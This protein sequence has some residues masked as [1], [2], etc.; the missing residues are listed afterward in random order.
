[1]RKGDSMKKLN[2]FLLGMT[3]VVTNA[4]VSVAQAQDLTLRDSP[5][6]MQGLRPLGMGN[7]FIATDG[8]DINSLF[9]NPAGIAD[10][11]KKIEMD[12]LSLSA[13]VSSGAIGFVGDVLDLVDDLDGA[14]DS[15]AEV[16]QLNQFAA[17]HTGEYQEAGVHLQIANFR[18]KYIA[19]SLF[20]NNR[21]VL[22]LTNPQSSTV[23][24]EVLS[25]AGL[26]VGGAYSFLDDLVE[27]GGALKFM[28]RHLIDS[29]ISERAVVATSDTSDIV[30]VDNMGFGVGVDLGVKSRLPITGVKAIAYLDPVFALTWQDV[31]NTRFTGDVG[32]TPQSLSFGMAVHPKFHEKLINTFAI[33]YRDVNRET[34]FI[35]KFHMGYELMFPNI[36]KFFPSAAVRLG[37]SQGY[38]TAGLGADFKIIKIEAAT[39]GRELGLL[40]RQGQNRLWGL[41]LSGGF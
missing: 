21:T 33:D 31:A 22:A 2:W 15:S 41:N 24:I 37:L 5:R 14:D 28:E 20:L 18:K 32:E 11:D 35:T 8:S 7:A 26:Q 3:L 27:V 6:N 1:M 25:Q 30:D 38:L 12:F 19:A 13:E 4:F 16:D 40:S 39:W 23:D 36:A 9:Y 17:S 34:A 29:Q 10:Y